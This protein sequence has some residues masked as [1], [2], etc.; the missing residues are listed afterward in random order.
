MSEGDVRVDA[1]S[2]RLL[3][4]VEAIVVPPVAAT[5]GCHEKMQAAAVRDLP[6]LLSACGAANLSIGEHLLVLFGLSKSRYQQIYQQDREVVSAVP[7]SPETQNALFLGAFS[8]F[9]RSLE[10]A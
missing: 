9:S 1:Q 3:L 8:S 7:R 10:T 4:P 5:V 2:Q 6:G